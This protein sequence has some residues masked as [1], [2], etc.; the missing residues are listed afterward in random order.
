MND[1]TL[2]SH[3]TSAAIVVYLIQWL[4]RASWVP[5]LTPETTTLSR[6]VSA[7]LAA[8]SAIG[9][10][11]AYDSAGGVLTVTGL[12]VGSLL[13]GVWEWLNQF[14]LQQLAYDVAVQPTRG[15]QGQLLTIE[16]VGTASGDKRADGVLDRIAKSVPAIVVLLVAGLTMTACAKPRHSA[17]V[18]DTALAEALSTVHAT[19]QRMLCGLPSCAGSSVV[20]YVPGWTA[21]KSRAFN[22][23][24]L[25]AVEAGRQFNVVLAGWDP[26]QPAP[27]VLHQVIPALSSSV[28]AVLADMPDGTTKT[29]ILTHLAQAQRLVLDVLDLALE[30]RR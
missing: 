21:V 19:E 11:V 6:I 17:I 9:L 14:A 2:L 8:G 18:V 22:Q 10:H 15:L 12:T 4:K 5:W 23:R 29:E 3:L 24:L 27:A 28:A 26:S 7:I 30:A 25:P 13:H 16:T 20:E 1:P